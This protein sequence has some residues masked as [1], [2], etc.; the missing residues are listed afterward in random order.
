LFQLAWN[1]LNEYAG[2]SWNIVE[3][4]EGPVVE[5][6]I[7]VPEGTRGRQIEV[8]FKPHTIVAGLKGHSPVIE[9]R[10][11]SEIKPAKCTWQL[12][13]NFLVIQLTAK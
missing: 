10:L 12:E 1:E 3:E 7:P 11:C 6:R 4:H 5:I 13:G 2:Y 8:I 9:G